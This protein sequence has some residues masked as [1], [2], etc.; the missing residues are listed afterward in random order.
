MASLTDTMP[1]RSAATHAVLSYA[2]AGA[3]ALVLGAAFGGGLLFGGADDDVIVPGD[4]ALLA[5]ADASTEKLAAVR[6]KL[7]LGFHEELTGPPRNKPEGTLE[8]PKGVVT[9]ASA[10]PKAA[11][12]ATV[13]SAAEEASSGTEPGEAAVVVEK[14]AVVA[15]RDENDA[16][17]PA[18]DEEMI[19]APPKAET[20]EDRTRVARALAKVLGEDAA[21]KAPV[22]V[23]KAESSEREG[24]FAVQ[25]ASTPSEDGAEALVQKLRAKGH[26]AGVVAV[27]IPGKGAMYRVRVGGFSSRDAANAYQ[28]KLGEGFVIAE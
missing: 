28:D 13:P 11:A 27:D 25:I 1:P 9:T 4:E 10:A 12:P 14:P 16:P 20:A 22:V 17:A 3:A 5:V 15:P 18:E 26:K 7:R 8:T 21:L 24:T 6:E 2:K 19:A 23:A